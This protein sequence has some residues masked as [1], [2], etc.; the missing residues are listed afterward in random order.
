MVCGK[1]ADSAHRPDSHVT[2]SHDAIDQ[3]QVTWAPY[4]FKLVYLASSNLFKLVH[5]F[6][7]IITKYGVPINK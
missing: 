1:S 5:S 4:V 2:T 3:S 6:L 7:A